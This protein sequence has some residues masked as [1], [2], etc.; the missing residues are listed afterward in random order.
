MQVRIGDRNDIGITGHLFGG[1]SEALALLQ[2]DLALGKGTDADLGA[3]GIQHGCHRQTQVIAN[4]LYF[5][6]CSQLTLMG[7]VGKIKTGGIHTGTHQLLDLLFIVDG[8][9]D[10]TYDFCLSHKLPP[11]GIM[12]HFLSSYH[13][14][15]T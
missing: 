8:R 12:S 5:I 13:I 15:H 1:Q 4:L 6:Q 9:A 14:Y 7:A 3:L 11:L 2:G 10:S